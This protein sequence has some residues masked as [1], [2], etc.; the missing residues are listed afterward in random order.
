MSEDRKTGE[1]AGNRVVEA[2]GRKRPVSERFEKG[3]AVRRAVLGDPH[4]DRSLAG[5]DT[6]GWPMQEFTTEVGWGDIW[7]RPGLDRKSRSLVNLGMLTALNRPHELAVHV[8]GAVR[9]GCTAE[10]IREVLMQTAVYC[11]FPAALDSFRVARKV[12]EEEG[13]LPAED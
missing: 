5:A 6:F 2:G 4:V 1:R 12:L 11:G 13:V 3:I 10:E 7:A 8:R 9:N